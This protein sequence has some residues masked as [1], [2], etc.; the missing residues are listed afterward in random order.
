MM[1]DSL[2]LETRNDYT[3]NDR[4]RKGNVYPIIHSYLIG[5]KGEAGGQLGGHLSASSKTSS[6][7]SLLACSPVQRISS[8]L[9]SADT[10]SAW[11]LRSW[12]IP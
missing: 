6:A 2:I 1:Y 12:L 7:A 5:F 11:I 8:L 10:R 9:P 4:V 3:N